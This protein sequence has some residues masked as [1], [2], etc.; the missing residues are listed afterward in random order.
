[1]FRNLFGKKPATGE[2]ARAAQPEATAAPSA[3][4][5]D[6]QPAEAEHPAIAAMLRTIADKLPEDPLVGAKI[7][8]KEIYHSTMKALQ[9]ERG[10]HVETLFT[11]LGA[12]AGFAC[13]MGLR[14]EYAARSE[15]PPFVVIQG[16]DGHV[17]FFGD[18][19]NAPLAETQYSVWSLVAGQAQNLGAASLPDLG[20]TFTHVS[21]T[22]GTEGFGVPR[23]PG[24]GRSNDL[25]V[26]LLQV[27]WPHLQPRVSKFC[28]T[29]TT[30]HIAYGLA[31]QEAMAMAKSAINPGAAATIVMECAIPMSK[32]H[33][34]EFGLA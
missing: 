24:E 20:E 22:C 15:T 11:A 33:A 13:Q 25:P 26:R 23:Y 27:F 34:Q 2:P 9:N 7:A 30:W 10:V 5:P 12:L 31:I 17:F 3:A 21:K 18:I 6:A 19:L 8:S 1:M 14:A 29:P 32:I 28:M 4:T 16:V